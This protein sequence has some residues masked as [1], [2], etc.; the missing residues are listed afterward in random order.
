[1]TGLVI[2]LELAKRSLVEL[3]QHLAQRRSFGVTGRKTLS[4]YFSQRADEGV[5]V[6]V[7]NLTVLIA[8]P[9]IGARFFHAA[10]LVLKAS[11]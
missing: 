11:I 2:A 4:I 5:S 1:M 3:M 8:V 10:L 7:T 9:T 6:L